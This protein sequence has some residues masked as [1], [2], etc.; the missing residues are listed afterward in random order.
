[1]A[2]AYCGGPVMMI[3]WGEDHSP[4][5]V[6]RWLLRRVFGYLRRYWRRGALALGW[7]LWHS[8]RGLAPAVPDGYDT[9]VGEHG[10]RLNGGEQL[11]VAIARV[12]LK[13]PRIL[14]LDE[15]TSHLGT[16]SEQ[17]IQAALG[18]L[19][20]KVTA[21]VIVHRVSTVLA[22]DQIL[23]MNHGRFVER[24]THRGLVEQDGLYAT[25]Y[26]RRFRAAADPD[27]LTA[28]GA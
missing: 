9:V 23:V 26:E 13:D 25:L 16:R 17:P 11:R 22:A 10:H 15:A 20:K 24:G 28:I 21:F 27:E 4:P 6:E 14:I 18:E 19:F 1:M 5:M 7:I 2:Q 8:V 3:D 12:I